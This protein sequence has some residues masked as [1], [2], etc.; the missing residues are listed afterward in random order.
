[1]HTRRRLLLRFVVCCATMSLFVATATVFAEELIGALTKVDVEGKKITVVDKD[2][3]ETE[4]K[5]T[6][7]TE[8]PTKKDTKYDLEK[9]NSL[10]KERTDAGKKVNVKVTYDKNVASKIE[11]QKKAAKKKDN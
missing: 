1:M 9:L 8:Y 6:D 4:I 2:E 11:F 7:E 3:K 5:V 10:V